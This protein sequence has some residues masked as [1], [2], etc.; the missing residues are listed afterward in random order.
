MR[1]GGFHTPAPTPARANGWPEKAAHNC[2]RTLPVKLAAS[3][4]ETSLQETRGHRLVGERMHTRLVSTALGLAALS[5]AEGG[6][7]AEVTP[8]NLS[9]T[10]ETL[11]R[12]GAIAKIIPPLREDGD[13]A[14]MQA[15]LR[16]GLIDPSPP[17]M[18]RI[19]AKKKPRARTIWVRRRAD[20]PACRPCCQC[21]SSSLAMA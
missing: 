20:F 17:I 16:G 18:R 15:A 5:M 2:E 14:A 12:L 3:P 9:L 11:L 19:R 21:Y 13:V 4:L 6:V 1:N 8:H 7:T 10:E